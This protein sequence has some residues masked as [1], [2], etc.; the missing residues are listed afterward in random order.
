MIL[1]GFVLYLLQRITVAEIMEDEW[2]KTN[3]EPA[4]GINL[5]RNDITDDVQAV[6]EPEKV[7]LPFLTNAVTR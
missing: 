5:Q 6:F 3:Y 1:I 7:L 2:F 4:T